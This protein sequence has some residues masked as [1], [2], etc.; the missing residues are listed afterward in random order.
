MPIPLKSER[1]EVGIYK[2]YK[3]VR[4]QGNKISTKKAIKKNKKHALDQESDQEKNDKCQEKKEKIRS[5][6]RKKEK[7]SFFSYFLVSFYKFS[8]QRQRGGNL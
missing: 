4:K 5:R 6:P 7:L 3:K 8:P 1:P 2:R